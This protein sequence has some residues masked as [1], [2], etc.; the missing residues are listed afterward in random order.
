MRRALGIGGFGAIALA[1]MFLL[2]TVPMAGADGYEYAHTYDLMAGQDIDAGD[3]IVTHDADYL[4]IKYTTS[5]GWELSVT[6]L[7]LSV[8]ETCNIGDIPQTNKGNPIPGQFPYSD[9][10]DPMV[11]EFEYKIAFADI[12][13][14]WGDCICIATHAVVNKVENGVITQQQTGWAGDHN[15]PGK[16]WALYFCY[17]PS[18]YKHVTIPTGQASIKGTSVWSGGPGYWSVTVSGTDDATWNHAGYVGWCMEEGQYW[19]GPLVQVTLLSSYNWATLDSINFN[20]APLSH[21]EWAA[22]NWILNNK[23]SYTNAEIQDAIWYIAGSSGT[24]GPALALATAA[25][26]HTTYAPPPGG[27]MA[28]VCVLPNTD[29]PVVNSQDIIIEVDP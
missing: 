5:D 12:G 8:G 26:T 1:A 3:V 10:H 15:F 16:N 29:T 6:H 18:P 11:T 7:A 4:Y 20:G 13:F 17:K 9:T 25:L 21:E 2:S 22:I 23:G 14:D 24:S 27:L 19:N 28:I